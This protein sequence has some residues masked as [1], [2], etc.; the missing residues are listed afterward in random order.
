MSQ[1][2]IALYYR[3]APVADPEAVRLW[4]HALAE[5]WGLTGRIIVAPHGINGTVGGPID[6]V[7][8]YVRT[9]RTY[10][11]FAGLEVKWSDGSAED[12]PRLSV[13]VRPELVAFD[14]PG[15]VT[16]TADGVRDTGTH[17]DPQALHRLVA[18]KRDAGT[19]VV[20]FDG[21]NAVEAKIGRFRDAVVPDTTTTRDF[22][23]E[24]DS[25]KYDHL[26]DQPV[27][28]YCTGGIRCEVL[29]ALMHHRGFGEV[30]QLDGGIVRY[31]EA[32]GDAGLWEGSLAVFDRR[33][34]VEF[35]DRAAVVGRCSLCGTPTAELRNCA[36]A[37][38]KTLD[39]VCDG[40]AEAAPDR[41][42]AVCTMDA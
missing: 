11:P 25:G 12:F 28:T 33:M 10:P 23:A 41:V 22:V 18:E 35:S 34:R 21:R 1:S 27:V 6:A 3:F 20:F 4:Q 19:P 16:V 37:S 29:T 40:C 17:L 26:K 13:K 32:F 31:G 5:R 36:D 2:K 30:Y 9:T 15:E 7:K 38:C 8:Q 24:L 42:C 39:T 14:V